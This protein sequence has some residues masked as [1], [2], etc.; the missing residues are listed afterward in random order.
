MFHALLTFCRE[1]VPFSTTSI[2]NSKASSIHM[3]FLVVEGIQFNCVDLL[4]CG[5]RV[6]GQI[7][8]FAA[9]GKLSLFVVCKSNMLFRHLQRIVKFMITLNFLVLALSNLVECVLTQPRVSP[10]FFG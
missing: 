1:Y 7:F 5:S 3:P 2:A 4:L 9:R 10:F 8:L 6:S